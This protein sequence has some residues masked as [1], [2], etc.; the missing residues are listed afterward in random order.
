[1]PRSGTLKV[2]TPGD[3]EIV[4]T[5]VFE[6]PRRLVYEAVTKPE[7]LKRWFFGPPGWTLTTCE[8]DARVGGRYRYAW[9]HESGQEMGMGGVFREV[10]KNERLVA[11]E[12]F[13]QSWYP[14]QAI[15]TTTLVESGGRTT[16]TL[17][18]RYESAEA[19]T[20]A[21]KYPASEGVEQGYDR[22]AALL[23]T[24]DEAPVA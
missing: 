9:R 10:V 14:G 21:L 4:M 24:M 22:L 12:E 6:A 18:V 13:D 16:L 15:V 2:T 20:E 8:V 5:R 17:T 23:A 1:M 7:I 11:T 19:R 3:R